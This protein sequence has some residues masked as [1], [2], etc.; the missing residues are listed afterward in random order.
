MQDNGPS[1][2]CAPPAA[3]A[4]SGIVLGEDALTVAD[5]ARFAREPGDVP[6][7]IGEDAALRMDASVAARDRLILMRRPIYGVTT[8]FGDS[9][10]F[11]LSPEKTTELQRNLIKYHLN[12]TGPSAP[13]DVVRAAMLVR[14]NCLARGYSGIRRGVVELIVDC[15][16]HG[17]TPVIPERGSV[18]A[19]GDLVPLCYLADLL[20]GSGTARV[21][22]EPVPAAVALRSRGLDPVAFEAKEGLALING[23]SF[24]SGFGVLAVHD[25][26]GLCAV[27]DLGTALAA[28]ALMGNRS[29]FEPVIHRQKPHPGQVRSA[30]RVRALVRG[31]DLCLDTP[32]VLEAN[33]DV[34]GLG[35]IPLGRPIQDRYSV[36]CAPHVNGVLADTLDW[37]RRWLDIE[38]NSTNDNPLFDFA[39]GRVHNGGNFY[40]GHV[41]Q[42]MDSLKLAVASVG[43]LLDRQLAM[44]VDTK[45]NHG[46]P[47]NLVRRVDPGDPAA[48]LHHGFKGMQIAASAL[49]AE[50]LKL[51][52]PATAFSRS[53]EAH[54]QDKV[55]MGTI[56]ARDARSVVELVTE[57]AAI[58]LLAG[59]QAADLRG[60]HLLGLGTRTGY[61]VIRD[62]VPFVDHDRRLDE[63]LGV[64]VGLIRS[65]ALVA[66]LRPHWDA[67]V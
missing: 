24:M 51:T 41:G 3:D 64:V 44:L 6:I 65:G 27:A 23:T 54:N 11:H 25:A 59:C 7:A 37:V 10:R 15:L 62:H 47:P 2:V 9:A 66:A 43:D 58:H 52:N 16:R 20:M 4:R 35:V 33:P 31:S 34:D 38:I 42:A 26:E 67:D 12:G 8:G 61:E 56:A 5:A 55:S 57:I 29:H 18:G 50:A 40:G 39:T 13:V 60:A 32:Q 19:S 48:G 17:I 53:T 49:A 30:A 28:E 1:L 45:F 21:D 46:L 14:A 63:D 22:G 36:R